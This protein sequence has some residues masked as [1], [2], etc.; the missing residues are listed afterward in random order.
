MPFSLTNTLASFQGYINMIFAEKLHIFIIVYLHNILIYIGNFGQPDV[1]AVYRILKQL[2][3]PGL[4]ANTKKY[5][6]HQDEISF[7]GFV[8]LAQ[9][10]QIEEKKIEVVKT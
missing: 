1:E 8:V 7:L 3:K 5:W 2:R 6:F 9:G 4:F 10:I